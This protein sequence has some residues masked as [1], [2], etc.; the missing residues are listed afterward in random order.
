MRKTLMTLLL[1]SLSLPALAADYVQ[2]AGSTLAFAGKYQGVTFSGNFPGFSARLRFD[3]QQ[4]AKATLAVDIPL[5]TATTRNASYD[6]ALRGA[7]FFDSAT[8]PRAQFTATKFRAL[9]GNRYAADGMLHLHGVNK[10]ITLTFEWTPGTN[11]VLFGRATVQRL[12]FNVGGGQWAD[13]Q[14][15]PNAIAVST[16]VVFKPSP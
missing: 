1:L 9:G 11:P 2:A 15:I 12:D 6:D 16:R 14:L 4:L 3:P 7:G 8:F 10:P 13:A 5:A